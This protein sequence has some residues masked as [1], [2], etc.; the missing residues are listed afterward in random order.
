VTNTTL[1]M[2]MDWQ[3]ISYLK[4]GNPRQQAAYNTLQKLDILNVLGEFKATLVSTVC[5]DLDTED[6]DLDVICQLNDP[7]FFETVIRQEFG[8]C[9]NFKLRYRKEDKSEIHDYRLN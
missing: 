5:V 3:D 6:S 4:D 9:Q 8:G 7:S 2:A 1:N